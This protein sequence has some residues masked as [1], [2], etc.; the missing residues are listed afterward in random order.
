MANTLFDN[1]YLIVDTSVA[2]LSWPNNA[3]ISSVVVAA[4]NT[5]ASV[6][7]LVAA[8]SSIFKCSFIT[9]SSMGGAISIPSTYTFPFYGV[10]F[11]TAWI[12][13]TLTACTAWIHFA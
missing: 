8:N 6:N 10:R 11:P 2:A 1:T 4:I 9:Q 3:M 7:F 12:P 13:S 5:T